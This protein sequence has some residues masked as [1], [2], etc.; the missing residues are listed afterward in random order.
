MYSNITYKSPKNIYTEKQV[1]T[2]KNYKNK[3]RILDSN[4]IDNNIKIEIS[5][6]KE[7]GIILKNCFIKPYNIEKLLDKLLKKGF[8]IEDITKNELNSNILNND[9]NGNKSNINLCNLNRLGFNNSF[10]QKYK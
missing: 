3:V 1:S 8:I 5:Y 2:H 10:N 6:V 9:I 4:T 7:Q